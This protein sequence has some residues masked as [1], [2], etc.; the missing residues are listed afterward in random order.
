MRPVPELGGV[1]DLQLNVMVVFPKPGRYH[2]VLLANAAEIG[3]Q[4]FV[5]EFDPETCGHAPRAEVVQVYDDSKV[6]L[7][8]TRG[9]TAKEVSSACANSPDA[10]QPI[11]VDYV[12][13]H[14]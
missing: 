4:S 3:R 10:D 12:R 7:E 11:I 8:T 13:N 6:R 9:P 1:Y 2:I 14:P 5:A